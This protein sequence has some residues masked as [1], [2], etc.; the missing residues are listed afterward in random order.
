M[1]EK[2]CLLIG[3]E[4]QARRGEYFLKEEWSARSSVPDAPSDSGTEK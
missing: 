3:E 2:S 1:T 4:N